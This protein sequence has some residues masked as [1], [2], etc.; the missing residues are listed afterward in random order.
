MAEKE[1]RPS[2]LYQFK[3]L[4]RVLIVTKLVRLEFLLLLLAVGSSGLVVSYAF[5]KSIGMI[6]ESVKT[7]DMTS[8]TSGIILTVAIILF[9]LLLLPFRNRLSVMVRNNVKGLQVQLFD[10]IMRLPVSFHE[11]N[12]SGEFLKRINTNARD[13]GEALSRQL[14]G[15]I[16]GIVTFIGG[17]IIIA[18]ISPMMLLATFGV[19]LLQIFVHLIFAGLNRKWIRIADG[20][21]SKNA[22]LFVDIISGQW[23]IR[24]FNLNEWIGRDYAE[25]IEKEKQA[26]ISKGNVNSIHRGLFSLLDALTISGLTVFS[27]LLASWGM[28]SISNMLVL[29]SMA[30]NVSKQI[31]FFGESLVDFQEMLVAGERVL[32]ML[33]VPQEEISKTEVSNK[34]DNKGKECALWFNDISFEYLKDKQILKSIS[35]EVKKGETLAVVGGSGG[36]KSTLFKL[37]LGFYQ[38][39]AGKI[40]IMGKDYRDFTMDELRATFAYVPQ[41]NYLFSGSIKDNIKFGNDDATDEQIAEAAKAAFA[42]DFIMQFEK[43]Y[44]TEV[45]ERGSAL[46]GGQRQRI[47]IARAILKNAPILLLDEATASLDSKSEREVQLALD[48]LMKGRTTIVV[49]HR[50]STVENADNIIVVDEGEVVEQG[51]HAELLEKDG[52]YAFYYNLQLA[53]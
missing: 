4:K 31:G 17:T 15:V 36:G 21:K 23:V 37:L 45:G 20:Q 9:V 50:L 42:H 29:S 19:G 12:H 1:K 49:A 52:R 44:D 3:I 38:P 30:Q 33:D 14:V 34:T 7:K 10:H 5:S 40:K 8:Y 22:R 25:I 13:L 26:Y 41:A 18:S 2:L 27:I 46:S 53:N 48:N 28:V 11:D 39:N 51:N 24:M 43:G 16:T 32:E 47:A 35:G 6:I